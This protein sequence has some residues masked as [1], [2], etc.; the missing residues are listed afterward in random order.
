MS[1]NV[2]I[3]SPFRIVQVPLRDL[4]SM[5]SSGT[6]H[7]V[8]NGCSEGEVA[9]PVVVRHEDAHAADTAVSGDKTQLST[10]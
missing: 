4:C 6:T 7:S 1:E 2:V 5:Q 10:E 8:L 3:N 9:E